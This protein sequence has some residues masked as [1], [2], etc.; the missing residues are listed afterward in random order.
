MFRRSLF[1]ICILFLII[2]SIGVVSASEIILNDYDVGAGDLSVGESPSEIILGETDLD[3]ACDNFGSVDESNVDENVLGASSNGENLLDVSQNGEN[4]LGV[5]PNGENVLSASPNGENIK[6]QGQTFKDIQNAINQAKENDTIVLEGTYIGS[7][8]EIKVNKTVKIVSLSNKATL[9]G[10]NKS[11]IFNIVSKN[12]VL[13]NLN[14]INGKSKQGGAIQSDKPLEI[15]NSSFSNNYAVRYRLCLDEEDYYNMSTGL[16]GAIFSNST[17]IIVNS[18][19]NN[20]HA[21]EGKSKGVS[22]GGAI[23][24]G[25]VILGD[26]SDIAEGNP[27]VNNVEWPKAGGNLRLYNCSF[28]KNVDAL[29]YAGNLSIEGCKF[30]QNYDNVITSEKYNKKGVLKVKGTDFT[31]N[32]VSNPLIWY[33]NLINVG[34]NSSF[35]KC[36]FIN[37]RNYY[38]GTVNVD[39]NS[40]FISCN[41][42]DNV[43]VYGGAIHGSNNLRIVNS[44]FV[45]NAAKTFGETDYVALGGAIYSVGNLT[46]EGS[47]FE[48]N[49]ARFGGAIFAVEWCSE[50]DCIYFPVYLTIKN[51]KF[52]K[53]LEGSVVARGRSKIKINNNSLSSSKQI[54]LNDS[55]KSVEL[56]KVTVKN[57]KTTYNSRKTF[58]V[59]LVYADTK[60]AIANYSVRIK[61]T[62]K[63]KVKY[64]YATTN[65]KGIAIFKFST[66]PLG[67]NKLQI[68]PNDDTVDFAKKSSVV[69]I[70]KAKTIVKAPKVKRKYRKNRYFYVSVKLKS[71]KKQVKGLKL[72]LRVYTGKKYKTYK[73]KTNKKGVAKLN[74]KKLRRGKHKV[75]IL[76]GNKNYIVSKK[77]KITIR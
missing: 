33:P 22:K 46:V 43:A 5:S 32:I 11:R 66:L 55:F 54:V 42:K 50:E 65:S 1:F 2:A 56:I 3:D 72:K 10:N 74:T 21:Y 49:S 61:S 34:R 76:S 70:S 51:S 12:V 29:Y 17:L 19:F 73:V 71:N 23:Y 64:Y 52:T 77:S 48:K 36:N 75:V 35:E 41:F 8:T 37:N 62:N 58:T 24:S 16:G 15:Y 7:G 59:K 44:T 27:N 67:T 6:P 25:N 20:N 60:K 69:K 53:N 9:N 63:G 68:M 39:E 13:R 18:T 31:N 57:L 28:T 45:N 14:F 38:T 30:N 47:N 4:I 40:L 26:W